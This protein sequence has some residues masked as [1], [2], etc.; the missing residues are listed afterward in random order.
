MS[1]ARLR[2]SNGSSL[3]RQG[4]DPKKL[5]SVHGSRRMRHRV[6]LFG[7]YLSINPRSQDF[8]VNTYYSVR[9]DFSVNFSFAHRSRLLGQ[10]LSGIR[11]SRS[12]SIK[13]A[14][15]RCARRRTDSD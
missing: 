11:T 7:Q 6:V 8:S 15:P 14:K 9:F 1:A 10:I 13:R 5:T 3:N 2:D 12:N 4:M